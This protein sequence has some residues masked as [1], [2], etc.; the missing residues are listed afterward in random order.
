MDGAAYRWCNRLAIHTAWAH[1]LMTAVARYGIVVFP[2]LLLMA[3]WWARQA[4]DPVGAVAP[5]VW[6]GAA[7]LVGFVAVQI[8]GNVVDRAR[9]YTVMPNARLHVDR[10]G[11]F[12]FPSDHST[13]AA[14]IAFGLVLASRAIG[15]RWLG[16]TAV[17]CA[18][19]LGFSRIYVG[20]H[21]PSDVLAGIALGALV[22][23]ALAPVAM[24]ALRPPLGWLRR[25]VL[26]QLVAAS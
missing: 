21:Y 20:A 1:G 7:S 24:Q 23:L 12:S 5:S 10:T 2:F 15:R 11:D 14:A 19:V 18:L 8:V 22:A 17:A 26:R 25:G 6:A 3:W 9:P 4:D 13:A 16:Y